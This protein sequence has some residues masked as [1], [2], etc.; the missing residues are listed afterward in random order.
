MKKKFDTTNISRVAFFNILGPI[1]LN[2]I[3]FFTVPIFTRILGPTN[4]GIYSLY[5]TYVSIITIIIGL[6]T[7]GSIP[8]ASISYKSEK[9][10]KRYL[11]SITSLSLC[12]FLVILIFSLIFLKPISSLIGMNKVIV[13][14]I[15]L[16]SFFGFCCNIA[17]TYF[18]FKKYTYKS[19]VISVINALSNIIISLIMLNCIKD[20]NMLYMGRIIGSALPNI[21]IGFILMMIIFMNGKVFFLKKYWKFCLPLCIPLVFHGLS[22]IILSQSDRIMLKGITGSV[23]LVGIYS[24]SYSLANILNVIWGALNSTWVPF[25]YDYVTNSD[26]ESIKRKSKNYLQLYT[27]LTIGFILLCPEV[28]KICGSREFLEGIKLTP[29]LAASMFMIF[30]Y[31]F[32]ANFEF[33]NQKTIHIATGTVL[34]GICNIILNFLLIPRYNM[35]G[36][37]VATLISYTLLFIFH[38]L[39]C[40]KVIKNNYHYKLSLFIPYCLVVLLSSIVFYLTIDNGVV[41]WSIGTLLGSYLFRNIYKRKSIF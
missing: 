6:Q 21:I 41:R 30:L 19:F 12:N 16:Q 29:I 18:T 10:Q 23:S 17:I 31:S 33:Y 8:P 1:I 4:Y 36:A 38:Q 37:A 24:L 14:L 39:V 35:Y 20:S 22:G 9:E 5:L 25:Y 32:P 13:I 7:Q 34:A 2:G 28:L 40:S 15:L 26:L 3:N 11:S 27:I